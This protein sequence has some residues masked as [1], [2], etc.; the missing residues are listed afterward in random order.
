[1]IR[2]ITTIIVCFM[3]AAPAGAANLELAWNANTEP[4]LAGYRVHYGT[5][6]RN[7]GDSVDVGDTTTYRLNGL[8][9][10]ITYYLAVTAYDANDNESSFSNEVFSDTAGDSMPDGW[11]VEYFGD[12][13]QE[14][15]EDYD[16]DALNNL[17]EYQ[18]GTDPTN[19]DTDY[20]GIPDG[21]EVWFGLNPLDPSDA[22]A[23]TNGDGLT[24]LEE[25][26][27][28]TDPTRT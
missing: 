28:G 2:A 4:D 19:A 27:G 7:Y 1:M 13:A 26:I 16:K 24:N 15:E 6:P 9:E 10:G 17:G 3:F 11:E 12:T 8:L 25:Y 20:D 18:H 5:A 21:W 22:S 23:D 14:P